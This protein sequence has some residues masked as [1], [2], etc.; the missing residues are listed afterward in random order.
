MLIL[1]GPSASGKTEIANVLTKKYGMK[2]M[3]TYTTRDMRPGEID[4]ISYRFIDKQEFLKKKANDD[5]VE[6]AVYNDN[7][8]GTC[9]KDIS[10]EK[11]VILEPNGVNAFFEKMPNDVVI[12]LLKASEEIRR[13]RMIL[14]GDSLEVINKRLE[15]DGCIFDESNF[16]HI[17]K[18]LINENRSIDE[19]AL[20]VYDFY[21]NFKKIISGGKNYGKWSFN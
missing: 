5:F 10:N 18:I 15:K 11:I 12:V 6:D 16:K 13:N 17:D 20:E 3:V 2:R 8:Y 19:M 9:K 1:V 7:Y 21:Y 14:R 4:G